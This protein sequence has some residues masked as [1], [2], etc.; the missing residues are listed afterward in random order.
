MERANAANRR[1]AHRAGAQAQPG[2]SLLI[3]GWRGV[4]HSFALVNQYQILQLLNICGLRL[5]HHDLPLIGMDWNRTDNNPDFPPE[6]QQRIDALP[7]A[8]DARVDCVYRIS[9]PFVAGAEDDRCRTL[10]FMAT[11]L[12]MVAS[13]I[14]VAPERYPFFTR[15]GNFIIT[16]SRWSRERLVEFGFPAEKVLI[17]PHGADTAMFRPLD[18]GE[19]ATMR[20]NLGIREDE[21]VF[22]NVGGAFWNKGVDVLLLAFAILRQQ[23][24]QVRL[25]IKD[26]RG[27][28]GVSIEETIKK[29]GKNYPPLLQSDTLAAISVIPANLTRAQLRGLYGIADGY[30]SPYRA[31]G[32]NLPV[33]E[34]IAC[35]TPVIVTEGGA[36]D[37]FCP[38]GVALRI[39]G[40]L[41]SREALAPGLLAS[42]IE[43]DIEALVGAMERLVCG[44]LDPGQFAEARGRVL[45][46]FSWQRAAQG[47]ARLATGHPEVET[48]SSPDC[49]SPVNSFDVFDTLITRR[50]LQPHQI[51]DQIGSKIGRSDFTQARIAAEM[52]LAGQNYTLSDIYDC[53]AALWQLTPEQTQALQSQEVA[54]GVEN[55]VPIEENLAKVRHGDLL[56]SDM[57]L[58][59]KNIRD[60]LQA[61]GLCKRF[62]LV[63]STSGKRDG[64]IWPKI[65]SHFSISRHLG[66]N[67]ISDLEMPARFGI[68]AEH[69]NLSAPTL[70]ETWLAQQGL[71]RLALF[72][73][74]ARLRTWHEDPAL[75]GLQ[76]IQ[77]EINIPILLLS[78]VQLMRVVREI[79]AD[80]LLFCS[81]DCDLW[82]ELFQAL[83]ARIGKDIEAFYFYTSRIARMKASP[84]YLDYAR[85]MLGGRGLVVD[86]CGTGWSLSHMFRSLGMEGRNAFFIHKCEP[87]AMYE[88]HAP[89]PETCTI[90]TVI[91][92]VRYIPNVAIELV[93]TAEHGSVI[94]VNIVAETPIPVLGS[95]YESARARVALGVQ[96]KAFLDA[97]ALMRNHDVEEIFHLPSESIA[98]IVQALYEHL[99]VQP[100]LSDVFI[101]DYRK[102]AHEVYTTLNVLN[103]ICTNPRP[104]R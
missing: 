23:G 11:E 81:R 91:R 88:K 66:D 47:L 73:R 25:I 95:E 16:P 7:P 99:N 46:A 3:E 82:L 22:V 94:D 38:D 102:D 62:G 24:R 31:E 43:P 87:L 39:P 92:P 19:R 42:Y 54:T 98:N 10:T 103:G 65:T 57:Y 17:V 70:V 85:R 9:V 51:F 52:Q 14:A 90:H 67:P 44:R 29:A 45:E 41:R 71:K 50:C 101:S 104:D 5:F 77:A 26:Q 28:Y 84:H 56:V 53:L 18:A 35:G 8:G 6:A 13:A 15:D 86:A 37:D 97:L 100:E 89:T 68:A 93:N 32:F 72:V 59:E 76:K 64:H 49:R 36:T 61:A 83:T 79:E 74:E 80:R 20:A 75:R 4:N 96:R 12:G 34:A 55:V 27:L 60:L 40:Q 78:T 33:L 30:V 58:P 63:V 21:T 2:T 69:T 48:G 1:P